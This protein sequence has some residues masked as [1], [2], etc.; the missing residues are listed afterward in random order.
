[1]DLV[2]GTAGHIDHGKTALVRALTGIDADRLPEEK[3]R[4]ITIDIGFAE[5]ALD[6][7]HFGFVDVPGHERFVKNMLAGAAG[8][9]LVLLV[10]AADE[11]VMPQTREHFDICRLL[12][13]E[14][15]IIALTKADLADSET[16]ELARLEAADLAAGSSLENAPIVELS[17]VDGTGLEEL[18][19][20]LVEA[21]KGLQRT[22]TQ[23]R[24]ARL[25]I[26]RSFSMK[27]FGAVATGTLVDGTIA[28]GREI[29]LL[30]E[31]RR[32]RVRGLQTH[33]RPV[34]S[35][36][37]GQRTAVNLAGI[38]HTGLSRG[39]L[40]AEPGVLR[41]SQIIDAEA[42]MLP[43]AGR[44]LRSR[45]RVRIHIGTAEVLARVTVID[46]GFM[47]EPGRSGFVQLRLESPV[48]C[49]MGDR[50]IIRSY[51]PQRTI[52]GGSVLV[53]LAERS[54]SRA[55]EERV[56]LL[57][58]LRSAADRPADVVSL[59][60]RNAGSSGLSVSSLRALTGWQDRT[61]REAIAAAVGAGGI[62]T[63]SELLLGSGTLDSLVNDALR[64]IERFH[65]RE[66]LAPGLPRETLRESVFRFRPQEVFALALRRLETEG[67]VSAD[68]DLVRLAGHKAELSPAEQEFVRQLLETYAAAGLEPPK[69]PDAVSAASAGIPT[70]DAE[71]LVHTLFRS[72]KLI[73]LND[74]LCFSADAIERL[75]AAVREF[76]DRS[77]ERS[78]DVPQFKE[79][80]GV[81]RKYAIP[82]LE[83]LD[84]EKVTFRAGDKRVV[85]K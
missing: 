18:R 47:I 58:S 40:L 73:R 55:L 78:I 1:M 79:I 41:P 7:I 32:L 52:G 60:V 69:L 13:I 43:D 24:I 8:I 68:T 77:A 25:P 4:G 56:L 3:L 76:A 38:D 30:P 5:L 10:I 19:S 59:L 22:E 31:G 27:G 53:S 20:A 28:E 64:F 2:V 80:A 72:G 17:S 34:K 23:A 29:E 21:A 74:D 51:S 65:A 57:R 39:M 6:G 42:E 15:G 61:A 12:G 33:G 62:V 71:K 16:I 44:P 48:A 63:A 14:R 84:R 26:D 66:P 85:L 37:P 9:D 50:F 54:R 75:K 67:R 81:S 45:Q 35:A 11:G 83:Y 46:T 36:V 70:A 49:V 82:L